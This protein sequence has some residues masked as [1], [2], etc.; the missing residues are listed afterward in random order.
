MN[1]VVLLPDQRKG[2]VLRVCDEGVNAQTYFIETSE[3]GYF[4]V[5]ERETFWIHE[6]NLKRAT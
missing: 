4:A 1:D 5:G 3:R 6:R 2:S